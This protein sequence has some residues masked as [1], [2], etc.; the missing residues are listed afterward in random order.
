M[1]VIITGGCGFIG[2]HLA[3]YLIGLSYQVIVIDN[4]SVGRKD[5]I[6]NLIG[7]PNFSFFHFDIKDYSSIEPLFNGVD[8]VFH[9]AALAD[10]VPSIEKPGEYYLSNAYGTFNV[11]E[12]CRKNSVENLI[13]A[14]TSFSVSAL[15]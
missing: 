7:N 13:Y 14:R 12:C 8:Y 2:S 5:N 6:K 9:L 15:A 10:I 4:L 3:D 11:L 1:K